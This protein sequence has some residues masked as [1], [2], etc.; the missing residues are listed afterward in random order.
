MVVPKCLWY[1]PRSPSDWA[2]LESRIEMNINPVLYKRCE[3][4]S[5][6]VLALRDCNWLRKR[7]SD[8]YDDQQCRDGVVVS[9]VSPGMLDPE[10]LLH[11][12]GLRR[13]PD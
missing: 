7:E 6:P 10:R 2:T 13:M 3:K 8:R 11:D 4:A 9:A 1:K 5:E 12:Q